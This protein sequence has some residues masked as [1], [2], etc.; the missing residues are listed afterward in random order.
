[1]CRRSCEETLCISVLQNKKSAVS[2]RHE[3]RKYQQTS[4]DPLRKPPTD[5]LESRGCGAPHRRR[6]SGEGHLGTG[7]AAELDSLLSSSPEQHAAS[8][9]ARV[10]SA[11]S[12]RLL[13]VR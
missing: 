12:D 1:M 2:S 7:R 8:R 10:L 6:P 5:E 3:P 9:A 11:T 4:F 13:G